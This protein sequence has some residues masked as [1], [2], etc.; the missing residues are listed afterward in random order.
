MNPNPPEL[1]CPHCGG[2]SVARF[3]YGMARLGPELRKEI[4]E[5]RI[6][7]GGGT[8]DP[9]R[10]S[11][12]ATPAATN[13]AIPPSPSSNAIRLRGRWA[14]LCG[15]TSRG[16]R[17]GVPAERRHSHEMQFAA[18]GRETATPSTLLY[19]IPTARLCGAF[20]PRSL[21][22]PCKPPFARESWSACCGRSG[23][24]WDW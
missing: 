3:L 19:Q 16:V 10:R 17:S 14:D 1:K 24:R 6:V 18:F 22:R 8:L 12:V 4:A 20:P 13:G 23:R 15:L 7:L 11:G 2:A 9:K 5:D 21:R